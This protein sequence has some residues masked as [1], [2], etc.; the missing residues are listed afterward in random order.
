VDFGSHTS[1]V[2]A[3]AVSAVSA[4]NAV[5]LLTPG[6]SG[7]RPYPGS[8]EPGE[9]MAVLRSTHLPSESEVSELRGYARRINAVFHAVDAGDL[10]GACVSVN[11]LIADTEAAPVL[12]RH[13]DEPWH[14]HFHAVDAPWARARAAPMATALAIVLGGP[15][16]QRLGIC[17]APSCDRVFVDTSRN[18]TKRFCTTACQNRVKAAAFRARQRQ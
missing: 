9:L 17:S 3:S 1:D 12:A 11:E 2:V 16:A 4:V 15:M 6:L 13:G 18:G 7:G 8:A 5:N 14:L 10:D